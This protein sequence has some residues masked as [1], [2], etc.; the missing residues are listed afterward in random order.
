MKK[1]GKVARNK[2]VVGFW[3]SV[4]ALLLFLFAVRGH[5]GAV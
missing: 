2:G 4:Y 1:F 3:G 5:L